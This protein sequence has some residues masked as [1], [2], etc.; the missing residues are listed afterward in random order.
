MSLLQVIGNSLVLVGGGG[1]ST[2]WHRYVCQE[3]P[4]TADADFG[5]LSP[6]YCGTDVN[7]LPVRDVVDKRIVLPEQR[8]GDGRVRHA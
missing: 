5:K 7:I 6:E 8:K 3:S 4:G 1:N 2:F